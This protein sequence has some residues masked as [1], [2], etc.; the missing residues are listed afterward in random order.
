MTKEPLRIIGIN[1]GTRYLGFAI[2]YG[3]ELMDWGIKVLAGKWKEGKIKKAIGIV[4]EIID[5]YQPNVLAIKKLH[6]ARRT[7]KLLRVAKKIKDVA[8]RKGLKVCQ[9]SIKEI[10]KSLI[11]GGKLNKKNLIEEIVRRYPALSPNLGKEKVQKNLY[12]I[13][14]FEAVALAVVNLWS[15]PF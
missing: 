15:P 10:E 5:R 1:P 8:R 13:R 12:F 7:G 2:L 4:S 9:Y 11:E 14:M 3:E 6:P